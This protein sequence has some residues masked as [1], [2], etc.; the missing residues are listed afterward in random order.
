M[1]G[2][3]LAFCPAVVQCGGQHDLDRHAG[4]CERLPKE[5]TEAPA[6]HVPDDADE[7]E[8]RGAHGVY[9][10][11]VTSAETGRWEVLWVSKL[12]WMDPLL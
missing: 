9:M 1:G 6:N 11:S 3:H 5:E 10:E 8:A 12:A 7:K 4:H 2:C